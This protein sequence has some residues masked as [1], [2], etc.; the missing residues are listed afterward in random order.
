V[1]RRQNSYTKSLW[2]LPL[3]SFLTVWIGAFYIIQK[4]PKLA[5]KVSTN[6]NLWISTCFGEPP[7]PHSCCMRALG[8]P[9]WLPPP[10][11]P[12]LARGSNARLA[13]T[14]RVPSLS[15]LHLSRLPQLLAPPCLPAS[16]VCP[17][18]SAA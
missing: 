14:D 16:S 5:D 17:S 1:L 6:N 12:H 4:G 2:M 3:F 8:M 9:H 7:A 10:S 11:S 18:S 15:T 13:P